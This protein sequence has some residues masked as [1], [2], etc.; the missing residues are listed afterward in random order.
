MTPVLSQHI[1]DGAYWLRAPG[2]NAQVVVAYAGAIAP[3]L[4]EP[5]ASWPKTAAT[6]VSSR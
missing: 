1:V 5:R 4:S 6:S 2:P 3:E